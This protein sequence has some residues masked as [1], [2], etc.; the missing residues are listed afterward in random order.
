MDAP[1]AGKQTE[2]TQRTGGATLFRKAQTAGETAR[3][4]PDLG[5]QP[6]P[7]PSVPPRLIICIAPGGLAPPESRRGGILR[8]LP[9]CHKTSS[10]AGQAGRG[11]HAI[12]R[13]NRL[14]MIS[15]NFF[16]TFT[17]L[18]LC[19]LPSVTF[20]RAK[21]RP[22]NFYPVGRRPPEAG[23]PRPRSG[24]QAGP[25]HLFVAAC[26]PKSEV[27]SIMSV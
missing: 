14:P 23:K 18:P 13:H 6:P 25:A 27:C 9:A 8:L 2:A 15:A 16:D 1:S 19:P 12:F 24:D 21:F 20:S 3:A 4:Q 10:P 26:L 11:R 5:R 22:S 7:Q 17:D